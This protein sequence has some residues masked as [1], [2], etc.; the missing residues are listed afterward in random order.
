MFTLVFL[1]QIEN[2]TDEAKYAELLRNLLEQHR[3]IVT[4]LAEGFSECRKHI[5]VR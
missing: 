3:D 5:K 1:L 2:M 4:M